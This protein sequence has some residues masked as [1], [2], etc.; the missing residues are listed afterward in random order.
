MHFF[1]KIIKGGGQ[2]K[3]HILVHL[4]TKGLKIS[5]I[6]SHYHHPIGAKLQSS[7][8]VTLEPFEKKEGTNVKAK[9]EYHFTYY[10]IIDI[11]SILKL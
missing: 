7:E 8:K 4:T 9:F 5:L 10:L 1:K 2:A 11:G 6:E 3:M